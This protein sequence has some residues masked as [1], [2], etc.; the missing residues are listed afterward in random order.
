M[1]VEKSRLEAEARKAFYKSVAIGAG[2]AAAGLI[3]LWRCPSDIGRELCEALLIAGILTITV[4]PFLKRPSPIR[5][6]FAAMKM[7]GVGIEKA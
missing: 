4:D 6:F 1:A 5:G 2:I 7:S 3:G